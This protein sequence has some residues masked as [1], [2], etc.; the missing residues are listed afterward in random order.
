MLKPTIARRALVAF[1]VILPAY[2]WVAWKAHGLWRT[3]SQRIANAIPLPA[4]ILA[5]RV[6][7][8]TG[9]FGR[10]FWAPR[11]TYAIR[12][13]TGMTFRTQVTP[14]NEAATLSWAQGI[15]DRYRPGRVDTAWVDTTTRQSFLVRDLGTFW[16]WTI[17]TGVVLLGALAWLLQRALR[18]A[19]TP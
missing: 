7:E 8:R 18:P 10:T 15:S 17:A 4:A 3:G 19:V 14:L 2:G 6:E 5:S 9:V 12:T 11:I 16:Y 1:V 13:D